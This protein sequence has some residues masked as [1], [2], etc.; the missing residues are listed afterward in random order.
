MWIE[1]DKGLKK[2]K[3]DVVILSHSYI[4]KYWINYELEDFFQKESNGRKL[5]LPI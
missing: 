4:R 1:I 3:F 2:S 5:I